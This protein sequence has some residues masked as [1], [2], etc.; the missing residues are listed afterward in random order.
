MLPLV[1]QILRTCEERQFALFAYVFM[2]DHLHMLLEGSSD[3]AA[4]RST[5]TLLRQRTAIVFK[6]ETGKRLWQDGYYERVLRR[7]D[8]LLSV[9]AYIVQNPVRAGLVNDGSDYPY[10]WTAPALGLR[11]GTNG[12]PPRS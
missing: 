3:T 10:S 4:F 12:R 8:A 1:Q 6:R 7:D 2:P 9:A 11:P 5:M